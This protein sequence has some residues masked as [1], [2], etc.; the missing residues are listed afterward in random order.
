MS[1]DDGHHPQFKCLEVVNNAIGNCELRRLQQHGA[2]YQTDIFQAS[3]F[4][5]GADVTWSAQPDG[6]VVG[7]A[8]GKHRLVAD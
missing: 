3:E 2:K 5:D 4:A 8:D 6:A 1:I 7:H